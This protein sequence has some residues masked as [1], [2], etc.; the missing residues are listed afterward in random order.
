MNSSVYDLLPWLI[1]YEAC[2]IIQ[3]RFGH[4]EREVK[5]VREQDISTSIAP[6]LSPCSRHISYGMLAD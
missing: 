5:W 4:L 6:I 3:D 2:L 1:S